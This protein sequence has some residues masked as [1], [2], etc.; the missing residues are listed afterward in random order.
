MVYRQYIMLNRQPPPQ[1]RS[2]F[3]LKMGTESI[4]KNM[5]GSDKI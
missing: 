5:G 4:E 1:P 3:F 2:A